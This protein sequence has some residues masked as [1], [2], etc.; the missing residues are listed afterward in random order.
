MQAMN[1]D[2]RATASVALRLKKK[3][4]RIKVRRS[5]SPAVP[6]LATANAEGFREPATVLPPNPTPGQVMYGQYV[7]LFGVPVIDPATQGGWRTSDAP[8]AEP[9]P[10]APAPVAATQAHSLHRLTQEQCH[11]LCQFVAAIRGEGSQEVEPEPVNA[12][13]VELSTAQAAALCRLTQEEA[14]ALGNLFAAIRAV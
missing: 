10:I 1:K 2:T 5:G 14:D 7:Q 11:A 9:A 3:N 6:T 13:P 4:V 12:A 8:L